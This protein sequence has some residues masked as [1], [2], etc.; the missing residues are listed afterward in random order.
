MDFRARLL[1][2]RV[3]AECSMNENALR[4]TLVK[5]VDTLLD[6]VTPQPTPSGS[7]SGWPPC[8]TCA[9]AP[10]ASCVNGIA[11]CAGCLLEVAKTP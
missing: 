5:L 10:S 11:L 8:Y 4:R 1:E 9:R 3:D 2:L 7:V 6:E